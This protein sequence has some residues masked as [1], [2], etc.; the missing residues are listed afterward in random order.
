[1][2]EQNQPKSIVRRAVLVFA[3]SLA[4]DLSRRR[5]SRRLAALLRV[6]E[7]D[8]SEIGADVHVFTS[9]RQ[10]GSTFGERLSNAVKD[11]AQSGYEQIVIVG[12]DCPQ[13]NADDIRSAF[14]RLG[15]NRAVLG[16]DHR[17]G[18]YL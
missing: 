15:Q 6:P 10:H 11:L 8:S 17:G 5:W 1:M 13:L 18:C 14:E 16:P 7:F 12:R 4:K 3:D 2:S 9:G